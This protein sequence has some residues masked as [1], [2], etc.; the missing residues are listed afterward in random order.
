ML[1]KEYQ[2]EVTRF[3]PQYEPEEHRILSERHAACVLEEA[4]E[5]LLSYRSKV[6]IGKDYSQLI[7]EMGDLCFYLASFSHLHLGYELPSVELSLSVELLDIVNCNDVESSLYELL[8]K[9]TTI[10]SLTK[11]HYGHGH[12]KQHSSLVVSVHYCYVLISL[13]CSLISKQ[14]GKEEIRLKDIMLINLEKLNYRFPNGFSSS[15]SQ[16]RLD[17][18]REIVKDYLSR[19]KPN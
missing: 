4:S 8:N 18:K 6:L 5:C 12:Q 11:K 7:E 15:D 19:M 16:A 1:L 13:I 9:A 14:L 2:K 17:K 3:L 10:Y